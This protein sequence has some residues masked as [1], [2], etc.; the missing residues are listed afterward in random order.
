MKRHGFNLES[1]AYIYIICSLVIGTWSKSPVPK[2]TFA[3]STFAER[4]CLKGP[5]LM[6]IN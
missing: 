4:P 1:E 3:K 5:Y 2:S 6:E